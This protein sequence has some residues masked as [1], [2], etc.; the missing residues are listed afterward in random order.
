MKIQPKR[1]VSMQCTFM[2]SFGS[3]YIRHPPHQC[4]WTAA[5]FEIGYYNRNSL[6]LKNRSFAPFFI[7]NQSTFSKKRIDILRIKALLDVIK[8]NFKIDLS[9]EICTRIFKINK[10]CCIY[11]IYYNMPIKGIFYDENLKVLMLIA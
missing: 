5:C 11:A 8:I 3:K 6:T 7:T 1:I 2:T 10:L 4:I 9:G